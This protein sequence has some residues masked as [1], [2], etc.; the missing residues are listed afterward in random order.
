MGKFDK[1]PASPTRVSTPNDHEAAL[2]WNG[3]QANWSMTPDMVVITLT[4]IEAC[5]V[6]IGR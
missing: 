4:L 2:G 1:A 3:L 5:L 6:L